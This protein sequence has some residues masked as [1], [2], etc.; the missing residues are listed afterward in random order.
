M[1]KISG[2]AFHKM[3]FVK[4]ICMCVDVLAFLY[5]TV[6]FYWIF[7]SST[8][9]ENELSSFFA[10]VNPM[11][12]GTYILGIA[13]ILHCAVFKNMLGRVILWFIY[14]SS[15]VVSLISIMGMT[16]WRDFIIF[17]PHPLIIIVTI[18][19]M[20]KG[21]IVNASETGAGTDF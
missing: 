13:L 9:Y 3:F 11:T 7:K 12:Y 19:V 1:Q 18:I 15:V 6:Y 8:I 17:V 10:A 2:H 14:L 16:G 4:I 5:V 21:K 20:Y